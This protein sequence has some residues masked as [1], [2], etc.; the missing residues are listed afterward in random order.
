MINEK[1]LLFALLLVALIIRLP[2][3]LLVANT[4]EYAWLTIRTWAN[5][6]PPLSILSHTL[7]SYLLGSQVWVSRLLIILIGLANLLL[8]YLLAKEL[9]TQKAAIISGLI[10]AFGAYPLL[11]SLQIDI[12]GS[13]LLL[14]YLLTSFFAVKYLKTGRNNWLYLA[15]ISFGAGMLSKY[16]GLFILPILFVYYL[17]EKRPPLNAV[18]SVAIIFLIGALV[19]SLFP[20]ISLLIGSESF[21][22]TIGHLAR[23]TTARDINFSML[24]IQYLLSVLWMGPFLLGLSLLAIQKKDSGS[25]L[26]LAWLVLIVLFYTLLNKDNFKPIERYFTVLIAPMALLIGNYLS[27]VRF[28]K[29]QILCCILSSILLFSAFFLINTKGDIINFYP[30]QG[31]IERALSLDWNFYMPITGSSGPVG[32]YI[33]FYIIAISF[34]LAGLLLALHLGLRLAHM[35]KASKWLLIALLSVGAA[36]NLMFVQELLFSPTSPNINQINI[37]MLDYARA[38]NLPAPVY[39]F[40]NYAWGYYLGDRYGELNYL[41]FG[42]ENDEGKI[43][44]ATNN[45]TLLIIDFP[46]IN[47]DSGFWKSLSKCELKAEFEDKGVILGY[48]Y[49][50]S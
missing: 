39:I 14:F 28:D 1:K 20:L 11:A 21:L 18:K 24:L 29:K 40:R 22:G 47:K 8:V 41:D 42:I 27:K 26:P 4:D 44:E 30:K 13:F 33:N 10:M 38:H 49:K 17:L 9:Y 32:F 35:E 48:V 50:C 34:I 45:S 37:D 25:R 7:F 6:H 15:G 31:Y 12:D 5:W 46:Q 3:F 2:G 43:N 16:T 19:F 36:Y 23:Y